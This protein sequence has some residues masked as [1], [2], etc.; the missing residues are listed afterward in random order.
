MNAEMIK[1]EIEKRVEM[2]RE[3]FET[4]ATEI[5]NHPEIA[6]QERF[7]QKTLCDLLERYG[8]YVK[9]GA[10]SLETAF[11]AEYKTGKPGMTFA[12]M[13]EY[14]ALPGLGHAC[15]HNVIGT[16]GAGA[17]IVLKEIMEKYDIGGTLRVYGTPAE[18]GGG[19][20]VIM[21]EDGLFDD[22]DMALIMHPNDV[23]LSGDL[24]FASANKSYIF[25]GK[26]AHSAAGPWLGASALS[27]AEL[28]LHAVD[29]QRVHF[30]DYTRVHGIIAEGGAAV[31]IIPDRAVCKF[32]MRH[33]KSE[34]LEQIIEIVDRC[35]KGAALCAGVEVEIKEDRRML[36][37][38]QNDKRL[39]EAIEHN[40]DFIGEEYTPRTEAQGIGSSDVGNV[41][42]YIPAAQFY[43]GIGK[44]L[45]AHTH[46]FADAINGEPGKYALIAGM[47][48][49]AMTG[50]DMMTQDAES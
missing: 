7:A 50:F 46:A 23:S 48:V 30:K 15:G 26:P 12:F 1:H 47:K 36:E 41:T 49:M 16:C 11:I 5:F 31:N 9:R 17:G 35:A 43:I 40:M 4:I 27:A 21:I 25:K 19:G 24:S 2:H 20:K 8:F 29:T 10:G 22:A 14:D 3:E 37:D 45:A 32:N 6:F 28:M 42:H 18:E 34:Y 38:V 33:L 13:S 44:G 39:V